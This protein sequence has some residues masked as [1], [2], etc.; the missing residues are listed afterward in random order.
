MDSSLSIKDNLKQ[1]R[2]LKYPKQRKEILKLL[3]ETADLIR[4]ATGL[5]PRRQ[6]ILEIVHDHQMVSADFLYRRFMAV[7]PRLLRY[8]LKF[9]AENGFISKIGKTRGAMYA[10]KESKL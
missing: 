8:D 10:P 6:E 1:L 9:L 3:T 5:S 7:D 4:G 2:L